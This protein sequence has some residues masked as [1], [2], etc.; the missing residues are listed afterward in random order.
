MRLNWLHQLARLPPGSVVLL[1]LLEQLA[2]RTV[3]QVKLLCKLTDHSLGVIALEHI[4]E[5]RPVSIDVHWDRANQESRA[6]GVGRRVETAVRL[7][8]SGAQARILALGDHC[9]LVGLGFLARV[10]GG[11]QA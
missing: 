8:A 6:L 10:G 7:V 3:I 5:F 11:N 4:Q 2:S 9:A 1:N